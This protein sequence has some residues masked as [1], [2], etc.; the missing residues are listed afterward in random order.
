[1]L[2][3][4]LLFLAPSTVDK[5]FVQD[6]AN[7]Y[8]A[9]GIRVQHELY[10]ESVPNHADIAGLA[11]LVDAVLYLFPGNRSPRTV[12]NYPFVETIDGRRVMV[13]LLPDR[14]S[15]TPFLEAVANTHHRH[16]EVLSLALLSQRYPRF[17]KVADRITKIAEQKEMALFNW[18]SE[19]VLREDMVEGLASGLGLAMYL[20][21][22]RPSGWVGYYGMRA[23]HFVKNA[24]H[25][26]GCLLSLCCETCSRKKTGLS[27]SERVVLNGSAASAI[28][29]VNATLHSNNTR[30]A[31][32]IME[33]IQSDI[34]DVSTL[35][36]KSC[37]MNKGAYE[38]LRLIGDPLAPIKSTV[39]GINLSNQIAIHQ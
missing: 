23:H 7:A 29:A 1:M 28:G 4:S 12:I 14:G 26:L 36:L 19:V 22:G 34:Q 15:P 6:L 39:Q 27:F 10:A 25:S 32:R 17:L 31:V 20:G 37:P 33:T 38:D 3:K 18:T 9:G 11:E 2:P 16:N 30:W 35:F 21:H 5:F 8:S 13:G 24:A